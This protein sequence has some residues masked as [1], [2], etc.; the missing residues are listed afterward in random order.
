MRIKSWSSL[1]FVLSLS[2]IWG[3]GYWLWHQTAIWQQQQHKTELSLQ[4][5][6]ADALLSQWQ[7]NYQLHLQYLQHDLDSI[8]PLSTDSPLLDPWAELSDKI[9]HTLW[10]DPLLAYGWLD[11]DGKALH[12]SQPKASAWLAQSKLPELELGDAK[13]QF[14]SPQIYA[15][16]WLI[17]VFLRFRQGHLVLWISLKPLQEQLQALLQ[18]TPDASWLLVGVDGLLQSPSS[19]Q[20]L[21]LD[22]LASQP[23]DEKPL[24]FALKRPPVPLESALQTFDST[25]AWPETA[26]LQAMRNSSRGF[27]PNYATN[28][29]GRPALSAWQWHDQWKAYLVVERDGV[30]LLAEQKKRQRWLLM[31][32]GGSSVL[33]AI[34]FALLQRSVRRQQRR[35]QQAL[36]DQ[37]YL[38]VEPAELTEALAHAEAEQL[39][40]FPEAS[41][42][43]TLLQAWLDPTVTAPTLRQMTQAW[44][45]RHP[46]HQGPQPLYAL[47]LRAPLFQLVQRVQR[48][49]PQAELLL[50][51]HADLPDWL[52][53]PWSTLPLVLEFLLLNALT[54]SASQQVH[55]R[56]VMAEQQRLRFEII[57]DGAVLSEGQWLAL[58][59]SS[60]ASEP[61]AAMDFSQI[62]EWVLALQGQLTG[63]SQ[64]DNRLLLTIPAQPLASRSPRAELQWVDGAAMLLCPAGTA[65]QVY[66]RLLRQMG[67]S[68]VPLDDAEQFLHWCS[69]QQQHKLDFLILDEGFVQQDTALAGKIVAVVRRYFPTAG[70]LILVREPASW[71]ALQQELQ[72][73]LL[74]KPLLP[75]ALSLALQSDESRTVRPFTRHVW[76]YQPDSLQYWYQ[77]QQLQGQGYR[78]SQIQSWPELPRYSADELLM[79]PLTERV[80][81]SERVD[82]HQVIWT[83]TEQMLVE[84]VAADLLL[85][86]IELGGVELSHLLYQAYSREG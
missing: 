33:L 57:D 32:L 61:P 67:L 18:R 41:Q 25:A 81:L 16:R 39:N 50:D 12:L 55:L 31:M 44:L 34:I 30:K 69:T 13:A 8:T 59:H 48:Q 73:Q 45:A 17:P 21:L 83:C 10:P 78:V 7:Q 35:H 53:L 77:E 79:L 51:I 3:G 1:L 24:R 5:E 70:L 19:S 38:A 76:L 80:M 28:Y 58:L 29:L 23:N 6:R 64:S 66:S 71:L 15:N 20:Q 54:R 63:Q 86:P 36:L 85:W 52:L 42:A 75:E 46:S 11:Q 27:L 14:G 82:E 4:V 40:R 68:L 37:S 26:L 43:H 49:Q 9:Q 84:D 2:L 65:Q 56:V 60:S 62:Q 22:K 72:V 47:A 74:E